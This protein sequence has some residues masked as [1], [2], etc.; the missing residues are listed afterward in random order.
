VARGTSQCSATIRSSIAWAS[1]KSEV[2]LSPTDFV[3]ED[4]R[5]VAGQF[6]GAEEGRPV[7]L[8]AQV[9]DR[10]VVEVVDAG[11]LRRRRLAC[12]VEGE[13]LARAA[14]IGASSEW[15]RPARLSRTSW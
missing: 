4:C 10:P 6:P 12:R 14:S 2:A 9:A 11:A 13:A 3:A 7:D 15:P 1:L 5:I 8:G